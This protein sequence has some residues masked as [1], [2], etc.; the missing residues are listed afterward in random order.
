MNTLKKSFANCEHSYASGTKVVHTIY[1]LSSKILC[2]LRDAD[3]ITLWSGN[4]PPDLQRVEELSLYLKKTGHVDGTIRLAYLVDE[5]LVCFEGNHRLLALPDNIDNII[6]DVI[7]KASARIVREEFLAVNK[8][9]SVPS[10]YTGDDEVSKDKIHTF[11]TWFSKKYCIMKSTSTRCT[12]PH[13]NSDCLKTQLMEYYEGNNYS[14]E[15]IFDG[16]VL[17]NEKYIEGYRPKGLTK[18][19]E[20]QYEKCEFRD[21]YLFLFEVRRFHE[22]DLT[23]VLSGKL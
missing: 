2:N 3:K 16:L 4:R 7:W 14:L 13:F 21:L 15:E 5:G 11:V 17:L 6:V 20:T 9:V 23:K 12:K 19:T 18:Y 22:R 8:A 10:I 1:I